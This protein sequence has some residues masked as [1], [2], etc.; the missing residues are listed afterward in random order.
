MIH[1]LDDIFAGQTL[2]LPQ[3]NISWGRATNA[4]IHSGCNSRPAGYQSGY[5]KN[6]VTPQFPFGFGLS[7]T[8]F[9]YSDLRIGPLGKDAGAIVEVS[10]QVENTADREGA[11]IAEVYV[12]DPQDG[13]PRPLKELKGFAKI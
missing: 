12:G 3:W 8:T 10:F 7:C 6:K 2:L 9:N 5:D 4:G 13:P 11:E 1:L